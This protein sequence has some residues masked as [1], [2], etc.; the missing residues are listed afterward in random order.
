MNVNVFKIKKMKK[1]SLP[2]ITMALFLSIPA[3]AGGGESVNKK[4]YNISK[5]I[6]KIDTDGDGLISKLEM[7]N[8]H[9]LRIDSIFSSYDKNNDG[10]LSKEELKA[11][12]KGMKK[13]YYDKKMKCREKNV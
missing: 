1:L 4:I 9:R 8:T 2:I 10:K 12:K 5:R 3:Y 11:S 7:M 13:K 6:E